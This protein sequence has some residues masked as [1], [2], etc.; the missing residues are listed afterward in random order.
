MGYA[1]LLIRNPKILLAGSSLLSSEY[2]I[3]DNLI[4]PEDV[5]NDKSKLLGKGA[6]GEV[7]LGKYDTNQV[8][9]KLLKGLKDSKMVSFIYM[10]SQKD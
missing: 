7:Y 2:L 10:N 1:I 5:L 6:F 8:A 3:K 9:I 4:K